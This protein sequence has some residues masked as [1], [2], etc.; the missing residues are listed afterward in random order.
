MYFNSPTNSLGQVC[1]PP[2]IPLKV[3]LLTA[4]CLYERLELVLIFANQ[5]KS[6]EE[7]C[8]YGKRQTVTIADS[9]RFAVS[10]AEAT[11][12]ERQERCHRRGPSLTASLSS[13]ASR[14]QNS[15]LYLRHLSVLPWC[16]VSVSKMCYEVGEKSR[17]GY[18]GGLRALKNVSI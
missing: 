16:C 10:L 2:H 14:L 18:F 6:K 11:Q 5:K 15:K 4:L 17:R 9:V 7:F 8:F 12:P 13:S 1:P 3:C